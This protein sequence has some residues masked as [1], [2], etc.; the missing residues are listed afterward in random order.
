MPFTFAMIVAIGGPSNAGKSRLANRISR[1]IFNGEAPV[2]CQDDYVLP[3]KELPMIR[4]H[5]DWEHP[6]TIDHARMAS[7]LLNLVKIKG[8]VI[9]EG[10]L[11]FS[12]KHLLGMFD[13]M[14]FITLSEEVFRRRKT[15]DLRWGREPVWYIDHIWKRFLEY[16][17]PPASGPLLVLNGEGEW[18]MKKIEEYLAS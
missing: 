16:G 5:I 15:L 13:K 10:F 7:D 18:P 1:E 4:D 3:E 14:I 11:I 12:D 17:K 2:L 8:T 9:A 6:G